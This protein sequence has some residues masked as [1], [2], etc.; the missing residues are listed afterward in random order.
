MIPEC[1]WPTPILE[2]F[3]DVEL[4]GINELALGA[5][6][7]HLYWAEI[8]DR[9]RRKSVRK[10][11]EHEAVVLPYAQNSLSTADVRARIAVSLVDSI[12]DRV[13]RDDLHEP[14]LVLVD[15]VVAALR[16]ELPIERDDLGTECRADELVA[17]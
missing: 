12:E 17:A 14:V 13:V 9:E 5:P 7:H 10:P 11:I 16:G 3:L 6:N 8:S 2:R 15:A 4:H 1:L